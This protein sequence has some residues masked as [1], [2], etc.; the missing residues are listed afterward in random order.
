VAPITRSEAKKMLENLRG[1]PILAGARGHK[2]ADIESVEET[3]LRLSQLLVD[4]P[5]IKELDVNPLRVF[6]KQGGC[7]AL[8]ARIILD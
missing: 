1:Y 6:H 7:R 3:L 2:R 4:F 8:D 5:E